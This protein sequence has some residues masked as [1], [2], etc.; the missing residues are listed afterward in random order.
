MTF[1][2]HPRNLI[3]ISSLQS[4]HTKSFCYFPGNGITKD[5]QL[6]GGK[7]L[8]VTGMLSKGRKAQSSLDPR[9]YAIS[10]SVA[11]SKG[12]ELGGTKGKRNQI[13]TQK[14]CTDEVW[15]SFQISCV[16]LLFPKVIK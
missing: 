2:I 1:K 5:R 8:P 13:H 14:P 10:L 4:S 3:G 12:R 15:L 6:T 7:G 9:K 11:E 16:F